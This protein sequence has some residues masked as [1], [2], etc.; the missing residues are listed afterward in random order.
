MHDEIEM[1][2]ASD[3]KPPGKSFRVAD[4]NALLLI[5]SAAKACLPYLTVLFASWTR[6]NG[7]TAFPSSFSFVLPQLISAILLPLLFA[8]VLALAY[9]RVVAPRT[10]TRPLSVGEALT[11]LLCMRLLISPY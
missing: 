4:V 9:A 2:P 7:T 5:L 8:P 10:G 6:G 11:V 1:T 3:E